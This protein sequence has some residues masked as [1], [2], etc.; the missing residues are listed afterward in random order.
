MS[1]KT[2]E[3]MGEKLKVIP[4]LY[5]NKRIAIQLV[6]EDGE[7]FASFTTNLIDAELSD[8][9]ITIPVWNMPQE[10]VN[11]A[12]ATGMFEATQRT[13]PAGRVEAPVWR[14]VDPSI[15]D[16]ISVIRKS[17]EDDKGA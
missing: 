16:E 1:I 8:D 10:L 9:E 15:L 4:Q 14:V 2:F 6:C 5:L 7:P 11:D 12:L 13:E 17:Y 3:S